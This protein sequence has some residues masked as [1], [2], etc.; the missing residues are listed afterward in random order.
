MARFK[1][2]QGDVLLNKLTETE[3]ETLIT[4]DPK[5]QRIGGSNPEFYKNGFNKLTTSDNQDTKVS[6]KNKCST[7]HDKV[8]LAFGEHTGHHHRFDRYNMNGFI[9]TSVFRKSS[10]W[11]TG[12]VPDYV[13]IEEDP[14]FTGNKSKIGPKLTHEEHNAIEVPPGIYKVSIV[15]EFDHIAGATRRGVD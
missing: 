1:L 5:K 6:D 10:R 12:T 8:I 4:T 2:Q 15:R 3:I 9:A 13:K 14:Y 11:D 7:I